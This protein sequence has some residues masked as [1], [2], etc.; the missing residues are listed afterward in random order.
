MQEQEG[1]SHPEAQLPTGM[2]SHTQGESLTGHKHT[3]IETEKLKTTTHG[4]KSQPQGPTKVTVTHR[5]CHPQGTAHKDITTQRNTPK[6]GHSLTHTGTQPNAQ[7]QPHTRPKMQPYAPTQGP[8][9]QKRPLA[10]LGWSGQHRSPGQADC[11][12]GSMSWPGGPLGSLPTVDQPWGGPGSLWA[13]VGLIRKGPQEP[14]PIAL[15]EPTA[16]RVAELNP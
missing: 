2:W 15:L 11:R 14:R 10:G 13:S 1:Q 16:L 9:Q 12:R 6:Q 5:Q 3:E 8:D 7:G 4:V